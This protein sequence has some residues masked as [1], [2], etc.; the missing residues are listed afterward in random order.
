M[1]I[2]KEKGMIG[3]KKNL[4]LS[5]VGQFIVMTSTKL[6]DSFFSDDADQRMEQENLREIA[7]T[8]QQAAQEKSLVVLKLESEKEVISGWVVGK[9]VGKDQVIIK[10][11]NKQNQV[12]IIQLVDIERISIL[13]PDGTNKRITR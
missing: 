7:A 8:L 4:T 11:Q 13:S 9:K 6:L 2:P 1:K 5:R 10:V 12:R 3:M